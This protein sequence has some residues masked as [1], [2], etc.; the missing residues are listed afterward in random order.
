MS[1]QH[2][3]YQ[4]IYHR[5]SKVNAKGQVSALCFK[6][7]RAIDLKK[8]LWTIRDEAV[9]CQKCRAA[10]AKAGSPS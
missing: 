1:A 9:T 6:S 5:A 3:P 2:T 8:A 7:P 10:I 4:K